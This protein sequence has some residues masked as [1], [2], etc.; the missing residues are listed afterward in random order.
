MLEKEEETPSERNWTFDQ[1]KS[2]MSQV[3]TITLIIG[4]ISFLVGVIYCYVERRRILKHLGGL[5]RYPEIPIMGSTH[6]IAFRNTES[7]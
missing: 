4:S 7:G 2:I 6:L 5:N 1:I 3:W